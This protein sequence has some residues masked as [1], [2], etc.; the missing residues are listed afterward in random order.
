MLIQGKKVYLNTVDFCDLD[1]ICEVELNE[2]LWKYE[3]DEEKDVL[4]IKNSY[5]ERMRKSSAYDFVAY[6][7]S[8]NVK[9]GIGDIREY[10][11]YENCFEIG[12]AILPSYQNRGYGKECAKLL[13]EYGFKY[14]NALRIVAICNIKNKKSQVVL[15]NAGMARLEIFKNALL[16]DGELVDA[17]FFSILNEP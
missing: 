10:I 2:E 14:L 13:I 12:Y 1:F 17:C 5:I 11:G 3:E 8:T 6:E 15:E 16:C 9:I 7:A 4:L